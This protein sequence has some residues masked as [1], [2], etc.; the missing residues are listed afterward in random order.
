MSLIPCSQ[1]VFFRQF[2]TRQRE[3]AR[4]LKYSLAALTGLI[5]CLAWAPNAQAVPAFARQTGQD[6][7]ACHVGG[8]GPQLTP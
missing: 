2:F 7:I 5:G 1:N 3:S 6:C 8:F 4:R